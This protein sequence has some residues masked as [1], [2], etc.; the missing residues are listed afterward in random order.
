MTLCIIG[1]GTTTLVG[2]NTHTH[3][4]TVSAGRLNLT[5]AGNLG[6]G[7]SIGLTLGG[8][9]FDNTSGGALTF[10]ASFNP[11]AASTFFGTNDLTFTGAFNMQG[12]FQTLT[13][14]AGNLTLSGAMGANY[15]FTKAGAGT[16]I[17]SGNNIN[18]GTTTVNVGVLSIR[19]NNA[20]GTTA[21]GTVVAS[22]A[23][24]QIQDVE[25]PERYADMLAAAR[26]A[27]GL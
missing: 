20:L 7:A 24:L 12:G 14:S 26:V 18:T 9:S 22:G 16:L 3:P 2:N 6:V 11:N 8:G 5:G 21:A 17:L 19:S 1:T 4:T 13:V 10:A 23:A 27:A 15:G 25:A